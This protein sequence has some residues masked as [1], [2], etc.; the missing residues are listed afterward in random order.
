LSRCA[1]CPASCPSGFGVFGFGFAACSNAC[2]VR[3]E[4][5]SISIGFHGPP[6]SIV[7]VTVTAHSAIITLW[8]G[9]VSGLFITVRARL[10]TVWHFRTRRLSQ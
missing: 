10:A 2:G 9:H 6:A 8:L 7:T 4:S 5:F 3:G 1:L